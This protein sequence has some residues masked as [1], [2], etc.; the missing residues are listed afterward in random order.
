MIEAIT[1]DLSD[2]DREC[3]LRGAWGRHRHCVPFYEEPRPDLEIGDR[4]PGGGP[5]D[6]VGGMS[7]CKQ[8]HDR[9]YDL[10]KGESDERTS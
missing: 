9:I 1:I 3:V 2:W 6:I 10:I 4:V 7:C 5:D 8:C